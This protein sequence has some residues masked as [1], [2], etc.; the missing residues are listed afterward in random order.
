MERGEEWGRVSGGEEDMEK[1]QGPSLPQ[2]KKIELEQPLDLCKV[3][4]QSAHYV[5]NQLN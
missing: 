3:P 5:L 4:L 1:G 2:T